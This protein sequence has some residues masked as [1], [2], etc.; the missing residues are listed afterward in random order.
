MSQQQKSHDLIEIQEYQS[1][2]IPPE[3][4]PT[5]PLESIGTAL[6]QEVQAN[7][8]MTAQ[9]EERLK[10]LETSLKTAEN[11]I[12]ELEAAPEDHMESR[13]KQESTLNAELASL[14]QQLQESSE[15]E[16]L[17][18]EEL[19]KKRPNCKNFATSLEAERDDLEERLMNQLAQLNGSIAGY[20]QEASDSR[21]RLTDMQRELEKLERERAELEAEVASEGTGQPGWKRT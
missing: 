9:T 4:N 20:Q 1:D 17:Q 12:R 16:V 19:S 8:E 21:D 6:E 2:G 13:N 3:A 10:E 14:K 7:V 11:K 18:K 5:L 15:R